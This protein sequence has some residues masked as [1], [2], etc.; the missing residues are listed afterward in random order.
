MSLS[1]SGQFCWSIFDILRC[2]RL[3]NG[4]FRSADRIRSEETAN[5]ELERPRTRKDRLDTEL[6]FDMFE[7]FAQKRRMTQ[8]NAT[9]GKRNKFE[10]NLA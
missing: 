4:S 8:L 10:D 1:G 2:A 7:R 3:L 6:K 9:S 5:S